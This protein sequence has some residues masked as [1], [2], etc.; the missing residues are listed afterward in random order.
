MGSGVVTW[1][2]EMY[3]IHGIEPDGEPMT[4]ER[5]VG[6]AEPDDRMRISA[7]VES[8]LSN[9]M[10]RIPEI[11]Y[12]IVRPDGAKRT[13]Y[14]MGRAV[15]GEDGALLRVVGTVEDVTL[16]RELE[17]EHRIAETLQQALLPD[18][19]PSLAGIGLAASYV[20]AEGRGPPPEVTG[21]T[22]SNSPEAGSL[23]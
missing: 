14:G 23:S 12:R 19:L 1:S 7:N 2:E 21:T 11:E 16:R 18:Q 10:D 13:L 15:H 4:F 9:G 6:F 22:S 5:A 17:R 8:A 3:R 20:P